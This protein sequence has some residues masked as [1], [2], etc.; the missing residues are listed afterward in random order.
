MHKKYDFTVQNSGS[1]DDF[2]SETKSLVDLYW[3]T[4]YITPVDR[5]ASI[6]LLRQ[7]APRA[8][9]IE[10]ELFDNA[11]LAPSAVP[12]HATAAEV[13]KLWCFAE[14]TKSNRYI[15]PQFEVS[16]DCHW[17]LQ[18]RIMAGTLRFLRQPSALTAGFV[19]RNAYA[20]DYKAPYAFRVHR[21]TESFLRFSCTPELPFFHLLAN[22]LKNKDSTDETQLTE[23]AAYF[24]FQE[25]CLSAF[26]SI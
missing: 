24:W 1:W 10:D 3:T 9:S 4:Q 6:D 2:F 13:M 19:L 21:D 16:T 22:F 14:K 26:S 23:F 15:P 12:D 11:M 18:H 7:I 8:E 25:R 5:W 17:L 20:L